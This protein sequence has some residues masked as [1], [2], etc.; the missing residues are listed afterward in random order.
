MMRGIGIGEVIESRRDDMPVGRDGQRLPRLAGVLPRR[1]PPAG[2][3]ALGPARS[4]AGAANRPSSGALGHTGITAYM[5]IDFADA[6]GGR[7][8]VISAACGAV[9]S[10]AGQIAKRARRPRRRHRRRPG[11]VRPRGREA[12]LR[13]LRRPPRRRLARAARRRH[14]GRHR[15][16]LRER[17]RPDHGPRPRCASTSA[18]ASPSAA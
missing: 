8:V 7:D 12:R 18:P 13:R 5:G 15:R 1:R 6:E 16:R 14:P 11:E 9:G 3:A 17:R 4:A 10:I 2:G